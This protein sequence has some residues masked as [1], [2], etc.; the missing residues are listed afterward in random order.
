MAAGVTDRLW[1][2]SDVVDMIEAFEAS[3]KRAAA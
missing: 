2:M 1:E 3:R